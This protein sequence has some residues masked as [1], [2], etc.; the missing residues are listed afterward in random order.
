MR[1][2]VFEIMRAEAM[3]AD[4]DRERE[5]EISKARHDLSRLVEFQYVEAVSRAMSTPFR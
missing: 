4:S 3:A 5:E 1:P 2:S